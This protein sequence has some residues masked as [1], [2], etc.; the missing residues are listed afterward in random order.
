MF[1]ATVLAFKQDYGQPID[2]YR[3]EIVLDS[4]NTGLRTTNKTK[5]SIPLAIIAVEDNTWF[6]WRPVRNLQAG[7]LDVN[8]IQVVVDPADLPI[9]PVLTDYFVFRSRRYDIVEII[10]YTDFSDTSVKTL[11]EPVAFYV[12]KIKEYQGGKTTEIQELVFED[13]LVLSDVSVITT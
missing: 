7:F 13:K 4:V 3:E 5:Y 12:F 11:G 1:K 2:L 9:A 10:R 6:K 8:T